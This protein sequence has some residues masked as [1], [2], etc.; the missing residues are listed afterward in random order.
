MAKTK[1]RKFKSG[2]VQQAPGQA[3]VKTYL[4]CLERLMEGAQETDAMRTLKRNASPEEGI[5][6]SRLLWA[7]MRSARI[8]EIPR[9]TVNAFNEQA[10]EE[11][12]RQLHDIGSSQLMG[13]VRVDPK[14]GDFDERSETLL[15][16][17][18]I[19]ARDMPFPGPLPFATTYLGFEDG[20]RLN[21][22]Q[23]RMRIRGDHYN[24]ELLG[25]LM[26]E[27]PEP[28]IVEMVAVENILTQDRF[29]LPAVHY[30]MGSWDTGRT[31]SPWVL[32]N[33]IE[34]LNSH[35]VVIDRS[36]PTLALKQA[37][38]RQSKKARVD[39]IPP[40]YF[41]ITMNDRYI[42]D[43]EGATKGATGTG[44]K[45]TYRTDRGGFERCH[46]KRGPLP[47]TAEVRATLVQ[48]GYQNITTTGMLSAKDAER[49]AK[50]RKPMK[51]HDEWVAIRYKWI[52]ET[53]SPQNP[54][55]PYVP[56]VRV[57]QGYK[58]TATLKRKRIR[59]ILDPE[60]D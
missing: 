35:R 50:R 34:M 60:Q 22:A 55:L 41:T 30:H 48:Q 18:D 16:D 44:V 42:E 36:R 54:D 53:I 13:E 4:Y 26:V 56:A 1:K 19:L 9:K 17:V 51:R 24:L 27:G 23:S 33:I 40:P 28:E 6:M 3:A 29:L 47:L 5:R 14:T 38:K 15:R 20:F 11:L 49:L 39:M 43:S 57:P 52:E 21:K 2:E 10:G 7:K 32:T 46:V 59:S 25:F 8:F 58:E 37:F 31:M 45:R 12:V